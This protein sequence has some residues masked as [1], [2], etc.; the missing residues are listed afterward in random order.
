MN[1][2]RSFP[3][4][5]RWR[6]PAVAVSVLGLATLAGVIVARLQLGSSLPAMALLGAALAG[7]CAWMAIYALDRGAGIA[8][9]S[10][11]TLAA[12]AFL[13]LPLNGVRLSASAS[14]G[15]AFLLVLAVPFVF[16]FATGRVVGA[17]PWLLVAMG[18]VI[19]AV[20][21]Q[22][23]AGYDL[24]LDVV[25]G[26]QLVIAMAAT[27][28]LL[29]G[30]SRKSAYRDA[31]VLCWLVGSSLAVAAALSDA[32]GLTSVGLTVTGS[33]WDSRFAGLTVHP[34]HLGLVAVMAL[35]G[36]M[37]LIATGQTRFRVALGCALAVLLP[38]GVFVS[39]SRAALIALVVVVVLALPV[40]ARARGVRLLVFA[41]AGAGLVA[42]L[43]LV[44]PASMG[45]G[46]ARLLDVSASASANEDRLRD[47]TTSLLSFYDA[48]LL[49]GAGFST[50]KFANNLVLQTLQAGG[51]LAAL[52]F[53]IYLAG[54]MARG[55]WTSR[56]SQGLGA[57]L[58]VALL[59]WLV[60]GMFQNILYD[61][62]LFLPVALLV[63]LPSSQ[64]D[65]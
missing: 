46:L 21:G 47:M 30:A 3:L 43:V 17:Q 25:P 15:D 57:V 24:S 44:L 45:Y 16:R 54:A 8:T 59:G 26:L 19:A 48:N 34:N 23:M 18:L 12:L 38:L 5:D 9:T 56:A 28:L 37:W 22:V 65:A 4:N 40:V 64:A 58:V 50:V 41:A 31:F 63:A 14:V 52:G 62:F 61:R 27:P 51:L 36:S 1:A 20:A 49:I 7:V 53:T 6:S 35:P 2:S 13:T 42:G 33:T 10:E 29:A 11:A 32:S 39:G 60:D 55:L